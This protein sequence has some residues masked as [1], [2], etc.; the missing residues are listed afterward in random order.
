MA[1]CCIERRLVLPV[2][3]TV[4]VLIHEPVARIPPHARWF[5]VGDG[6]TG[7]SGQW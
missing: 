3:V 4:S 7:A 1:R 5:S 2:S 6:F